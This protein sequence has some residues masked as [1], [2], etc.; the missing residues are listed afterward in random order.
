[1]APEVIREKSYAGTGVYTKGRAVCAKALVA[2][3]CD[4]QPH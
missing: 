1:M 4:L 3:G 2:Q